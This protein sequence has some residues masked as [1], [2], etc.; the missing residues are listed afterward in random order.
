MSVTVNG[1]P[2]TLTA[3][4]PDRGLYSG[5]FAVSTEGPFDVVATVTVGGATAVHNGFGRGVPELHVPGR[6][7]HVG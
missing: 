2:V 6:T 3:S 7:V 5:S 1:D 4:S